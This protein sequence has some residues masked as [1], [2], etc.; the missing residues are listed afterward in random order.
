[1]TVGGT[2]SSAYFTGDN[3][4]S[5]SG[6]SWQTETLTFQA[7]SDNTFI[8]FNDCVALGDTDLFVGLDNVSLV[9]VPELPTSLTGLGGLAL[10]M[11]AIGFSSKRPK[12][13][14]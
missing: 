14:L 7:S 6:S 4:V 5:G 1:V 12:P 9:V 13:N 2:P 10:V 8:S 3:E 11:A